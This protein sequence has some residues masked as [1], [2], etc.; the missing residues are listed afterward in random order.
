MFCYRY[1]FLDSGKLKS[2]EDNA[3]F[4]PAVFDTER[5]L[6]FLFLQ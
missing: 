1:K 5:G 2:Y 4:S 3:V 6:E